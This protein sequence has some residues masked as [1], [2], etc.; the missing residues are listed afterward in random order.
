MYSLLSVLPAGSEWIII[1]IIVL[2][3]FYLAGKFIRSLFK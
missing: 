3:L 2:V 1:L